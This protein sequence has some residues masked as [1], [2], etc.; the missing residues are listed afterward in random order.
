MTTKDKRSKVAIVRAKCIGCGAIRDIRPG[1]V[2][3]DDMP[4]CDK[5]CSPMVAMSARHEK[6]K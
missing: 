1:G 2:A 4:I 3:P 5:C 6:V